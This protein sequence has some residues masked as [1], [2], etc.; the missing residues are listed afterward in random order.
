MVRSFSDA[1]HRSAPVSGAASSGGG[2][3]FEC[4]SAGRLA[5]VAALGDGRTP[6]AVVISVSN[7]KRPGRYF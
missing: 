1:R 4:Y 6:T 5:H 3:A 2:S 7:D